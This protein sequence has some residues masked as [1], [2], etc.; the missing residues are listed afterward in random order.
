MEVRVRIHFKPGLMALVYNPS[1]WE[2]EKDCH[3]ID[4]L[5]YIVTF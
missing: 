5:E 3:E 4:S 1:M 2:I